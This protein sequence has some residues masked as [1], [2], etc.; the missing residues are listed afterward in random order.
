MWETET[1]AS[2]MWKSVPYLRSDGFV[3]TYRHDNTVAMLRKCVSTISTNKRLQEA[4]TDGSL[5]TSSP[6]KEM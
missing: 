6:I 2:M 5:T 3:Y 1:S 4:K